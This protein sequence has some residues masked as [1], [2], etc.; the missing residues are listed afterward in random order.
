MGSKPKVEY[1]GGTEAGVMGKTWRLF[2][3]S[4]STCENPRAS[5]WRGPG[6]PI[7]GSFATIWSNI[8][9]QSLICKKIRK[10]KIK[11]NWPWTSLLQIFTKIYN[12]TILLISGF[13]YANGGF[14]QSKKLQQKVKFRVSLPR[15]LDQSVFPTDTNLLITSFFVIEI[16]ARIFFQQI[17]LEVCISQQQGRYGMVL[18]NIF[19]IKYCQNF[20]PQSA[21]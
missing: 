3:H 2:K 12:V 4:N 14:W 11:K 8:N 16:A 7:T 15:F 17:W 9:Q 6:P 19:T 10:E 1:L 21:P 20:P 13:N 18:V 5:W